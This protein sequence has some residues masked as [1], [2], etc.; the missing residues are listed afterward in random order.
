MRDDRDDS[1]SRRRQQALLR[2]A[3]IGDL[4]IEA[5]PPGERSARIAELATR[6]YRTPAGRERRFSARTLWAWWS[7]AVRRGCDVDQPRNLAQSVTAE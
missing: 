5:L 7:T 3:I 6:T 2:H 1:D 4:D